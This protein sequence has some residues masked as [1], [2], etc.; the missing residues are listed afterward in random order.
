MGKNFN[1]KT[2]LIESFEYEPAQSGAAE[3][4]ATK[5]SASDL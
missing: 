1:D 3:A 5:L 4:E 2:Q